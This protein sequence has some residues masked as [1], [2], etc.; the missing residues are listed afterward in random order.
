MCGQTLIGHSSVVCSLSA[1]AA[2]AAQAFT[3]PVSP[4]RQQ[5]RAARRRDLPRV[6]DGEVKVKVTGTFSLP[7][8]PSWRRLS[9]AAA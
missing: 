1:G 5:S 6:D 7:L 2:A 8:L 9:G 3:A 4:S